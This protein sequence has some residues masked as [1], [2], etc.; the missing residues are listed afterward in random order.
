M[1]NKRGT[2]IETKLLEVRHM[3]RPRFFYIGLPNSVLKPVFLNVYGLHMRAMKEPINNGQCDGG[4]DR[5]PA[6]PHYFGRIEKL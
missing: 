6:V 1:P 3:S 4:S 5:R 2:T